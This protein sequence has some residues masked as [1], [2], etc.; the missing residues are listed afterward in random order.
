MGI[1]A[2][3]RQN[4]GVSVKEIDAWLTAATVGEDFRAA[5]GL[6]LRKTAGGAFWFFRSKSP[7]N[8]RQLRIA[9]WGDNSG[10]VKA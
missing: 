6:Y 5:K 1:K 4:I 3:T 7:V 10:D 2:G 8:G 9:L